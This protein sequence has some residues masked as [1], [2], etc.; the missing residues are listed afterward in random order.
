MN[1]YRTIGPLVS[2][3]KRPWQSFELKMYKSFDVKQYVK[4]L[5][6]DAA[7]LVIVRS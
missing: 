1:V 4:E 6:S 3:L 7:L 5:F 2:S